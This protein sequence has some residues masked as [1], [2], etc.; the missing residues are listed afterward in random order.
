MACGYNDKEKPDRFWEKLSDDQIVFKAMEV[1]REQDIKIDLNKIP[2][3]LK[4]FCRQDDFSTTSL[5]FAVKKTDIDPEKRLKLVM[6]LIA[7]GADPVQQDIKGHDALWYAQSGN[8][9]IN[10]DVEDIE[11]VLSA[12]DIEEFLSALAHSRTAIKNS[13]EMDIRNLIKIINFTAQYTKTTFS[14]KSTETLSIIEKNHKK[15]FDL[16]FK[17][18][19]ESNEINAVIQIIERDFIN[20][21]PMPQDDKHQSKAPS[22]LSW[23]PNHKLTNNSS[24]IQS[25]DQG[26]GL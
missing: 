26:C 21:R 19:K 15:S 25:N 6:F 3:K 24:I 8:E 16:L 7:N 13:S 20:F 12:Q 14:T 2:N 18:L 22:L 5:M 23:L 11:D 9:D 10:E 4:K 17:S 1:A